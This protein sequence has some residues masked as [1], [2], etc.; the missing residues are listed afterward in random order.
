MFYVSGI[1]LISI[2]LWVILLVTAF[3]LIVRYSGSISMS[4]KFI[5]SLIVLFLPYAGSLIAIFSILRMRNRKA[6]NMIP[7]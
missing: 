2:A 6:K 3:S 1:E 4:G 5:L 7:T